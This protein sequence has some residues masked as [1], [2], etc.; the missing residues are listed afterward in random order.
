M[1]KMYFFSGLY[2][3]T[4]RVINMEYDPDLAF[5]DMV[6]N[7]AYRQIKP[8]IDAIFAGDKTILLPDDY[9]ERLIQYV[10]E[11]AGEIAKTG[12][13]YQPLHKISNL[14]YMSTGNG[15]YLAQKGIDLV[16]DSKKKSQKT[17]P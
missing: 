10:R 12:N 11:L 3:M 1:E 13:Y 6:L 2:S 5:I 17:L 14:A 15:Y 4:N 16:G 7:V 8:A 9:F